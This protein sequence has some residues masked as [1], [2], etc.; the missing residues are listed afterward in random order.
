MCGDQRCTPERLAD[1]RHS[2]ELDRPVPEQFTEYFKGVF[3]GRD[4]RLRRLHQVQCSAPCLGFSFRTDRDGQGRDLL[5]LPGHASSLALGAMVVFLIIGV[6]HGHLQRPTTRVAAG[7][8]ASSA[9]TQVFGVHPVLRPR[10]A[11][12]RCTR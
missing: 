2:I 4:D 10:A 11:R 7:P 6:T 8:H 5:P 1:I 9:F 3:V 12:S